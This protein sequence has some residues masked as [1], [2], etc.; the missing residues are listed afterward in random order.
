MKFSIF[1]IL[2]FPLI[3]TVSVAVMLYYLI[4]SY[5]IGEAKEH[6]KNALL[7]NRGLHLYIQRNMHPA[8]FK[9][10][11]IGYISPD[12]YNPVIF[13][14]S[15]V[16]RVL[17]KYFN[18]ERVKQGMPEVYYK[19]AS[20]NPRNPVNKADQYEIR[21]L[22]LFNKNR[23][24]K[25][26]EEIVTIDN[27]KYIYYT[28]PFLETN[29]A[30]LKCHGRREDA[31][32][33]L[34]KLY[35]GYGGFGEQ[36]GNIRAIESIRV[37]VN[38]EIFKAAIFTGSATSGVIVLIVLLLFS[39]QLRVKV[40]EKTLYLEKEVSENIQAKK[41]IGKSLLE[42]EVLLKEVHHR[43]KNNM[44]IISSF[45]E[46][47]S[48]T[49]LDENIKK[50][51]DVSIS[52]IKSMAL[53]H[54]K[55]YLSTDLANISVREYI[56]ELMNELAD[57]F[58]ISQAPVKY[59]IDVKDVKMSL[60]NMIPL[61]LLI[62]EI[63]MNSFKH[64]FHGTADPEIKVILNEENGIVN[65]LL[66][67]NGKGMSDEP[68]DGKTTIGRDIIKALTLQLKADVKMSVKN[69]TSYD[70]SFDISQPANKHFHHEDKSI[71]S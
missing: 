1:K 65:I 9:D 62:N 48:M 31:P 11:D 43:V 56:Q 22:D 67:D 58:R 35:P 68:A 70:I 24:I 46:L 28:I 4:S 15:Y 36:I 51:L 49:A 29:S 2:I 21:L 57:S 66:S 23:N 52:R 55:L 61:G 17:Q 3:V 7:A 64:A 25:N 6:V 71:N 32:P 26:H 53:I 14:S 63:V 8:F 59:S 34:Q 41:E 54:E 47:Q 45:L 20:V 69:G 30:C 18:E 42:K 39:S 38:D 60:V 12:Y 40:R 13:S 5:M 50:I 10:R 19:L 27:K 44:A 33:G 16:V 37:P